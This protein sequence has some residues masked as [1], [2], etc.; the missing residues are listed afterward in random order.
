M[1]IK[2]NSTEKNGPSNSALYNSIDLIMFLR[3]T[4]NQSTLSFKEREKI[5][6]KRE[7]NKSI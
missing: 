6:E 4:V 7:K 1:S 3:S 2:K 5:K